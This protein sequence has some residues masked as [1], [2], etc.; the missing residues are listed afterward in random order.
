MR[1]DRLIAVLHEGEHAMP[2]IRELIELAKNCYAQANGAA[3]PGAEQ[4]LR[5]LGDRYL[6]QADDLR[7]YQIVQAVFPKPGARSNAV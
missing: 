5:D 7:H 4:T 2:R 1:I 6:K 3:N